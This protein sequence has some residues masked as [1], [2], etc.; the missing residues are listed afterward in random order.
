MSSEHH[1]PPCHII[2]YNIYKHNL[3]T[4][5]YNLFF[6]ELRVTGPDGGESPAPLDPWLDELELVLRACSLPLALSGGV[7]LKQ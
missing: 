7:I 5:T 1:I 4:F 2:F 6:D 3:H